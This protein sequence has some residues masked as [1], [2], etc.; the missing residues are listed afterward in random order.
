MIYRGR[1]IGA[2]ILIP[3]VFVGPGLE[4]KSGGGARP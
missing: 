4:R 2:R 1:F 3:I